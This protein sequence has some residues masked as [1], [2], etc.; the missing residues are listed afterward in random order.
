MRICIEERR[1]QKMRISEVSYVDRAEKVIKELV[2]E[3]KNRK[4]GKQKMKNI[5]E[6]I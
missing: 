3:S 2:E 1:R 6:K 5:D 4:K